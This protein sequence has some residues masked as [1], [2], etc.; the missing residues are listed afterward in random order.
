MICFLAVRVREL[1]SGTFGSE[2]LW[3]GDVGDY[4]VRIIVWNK[5]F[6][7]NVV[8]IIISYSINTLYDNNM[9]LYSYI[10]IYI[11]YYK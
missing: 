7:M 5:N 6:I 4:Q 2:E 3:G 9:I 1:R 10:I 11:V 8:I